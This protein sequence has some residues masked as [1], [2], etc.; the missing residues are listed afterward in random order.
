MV[1]NTSDE[2]KAGVIE[3]LN[4]TSPGKNLPYDIVN[5][6]HPLQI[7]LDAIRENYKV[8]GRCP[9]SRFFLEKYSDLIS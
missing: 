5:S 2:I 1:E 7:K 8:I 3:M 6:S 4:L 9:V